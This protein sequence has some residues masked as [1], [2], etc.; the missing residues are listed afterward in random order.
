MFTTYIIH[1]QTDSILY[2]VHNTHTRHNTSAVK[3]DKKKSDSISINDIKTR[4]EFA[5]IQ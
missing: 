1:I 4:N 3:L 5:H 2:R